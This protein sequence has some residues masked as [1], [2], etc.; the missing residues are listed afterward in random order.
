MSPISINIFRKIKTQLEL[1]PPVLS[2]SSQ[3]TSQ[4]ND[5]GESVTFTGTA[6]ASGDGTISYQWYENETALSDGGRISGSS[7]NSLTITNLQSPSDNGRSFVLRATYVPGVTSGNATNSPLDSNTVSLN[8]WPSLS[9]TTQPTDQTTAVDTT[10]TFSVVASISDSSYGPINYLWTRDGTTIQNSTSN[11]VTITPTTAGTSTIQVTAYVDTTDGRKQVVSNTAILTGVFIRNILSIEAF[12]SSGTDISTSEVDFDPEGTEFT[13]NK[14]T[15]GSDY[16][17]IQFYAKEKDL[18]VDLTMRGAAGNGTSGR[19][20]SSNLTVSPGE[21]GVSTI[22]FTMQK[23]VEYT[24]LGISPSSALFL[25]RGSNLI[26][27]VGQGGDRNN[28]S[29]ANGGDGGGVNISGGGGSGLFISS[30]SGGRLIPPGNLSLNG[31]WGSNSNFSQNNLQPG[32][33]IASNSDGGRTISCT[34]GTYWLNQGISPCSNNSSSKIKYRDINGN[35]VSGSSSLTRGFKP[36]YTITN[37]AGRK[38]V[39]SGGWSFTTIGSNGG[40]G[41]TGGEGSRY[42]VGGGGGSG[43]SNGEVTIVETRRGGNSSTTSSVTFT[44]LEEN[45]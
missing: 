20:R 28:S 11:T 27:V 45:K 39:S 23:D 44:I 3:P 41:A 22:R 24:L 13:L 12:K 26:A 8:V 5:P 37:T 19:T 42:G 31:I 40:N 29:Y 16:S 6:I 1:D 18:T 32:D 17:I 21:G 35:E 10:A 43:Y 15:F 14:D 33:T 9:I 34:K 30:G 36:G 25:Y 7:T 2:F 4:S 38:I